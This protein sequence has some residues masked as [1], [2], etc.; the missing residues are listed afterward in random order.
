MR[1]FI[2]CLSNAMFQAPGLLPT[3]HMMNQLSDNPENQWPPSIN[4][5]SDKD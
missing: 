5:F 4:I 3:L 1:P 2:F